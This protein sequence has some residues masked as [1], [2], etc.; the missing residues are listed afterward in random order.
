MTW[1]D[2]RRLRSGLRVPFRTD[3]EVFGGHYFL[4]AKEV[5]IDESGLAIPACKSGPAPPPTATL[6]PDPKPAQAIIERY[7]QAMGGQA[8]IRSHTSVHI[9]GQLRLPRSK[10]FSS[11]I[12][13]F[14]ALT[15]RFFLKVQL[16]TGLHR[17]GCDGRRFWRATGTEVSFA[18]GRDLDQ[19]LALRDFSAVLHEPGAYRSMETLGTVNLD[20]KTCFQ[21]LLV[22]KDGEVF[23]EFYDSETGSCIS[24]AALTK[25]TATASSCWKPTM[26]IA[27]SATRWCPPGRSSRGSNM[28]RN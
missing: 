22:R 27:A 28:L 5:R 25:R 6:K 16:P 14:S 2:Y 15:N 11:P 7:V 24:G 12:E 13:I 10:G 8:A 23:D 19:C 18:A 21:V 4:R 9:S 3:L 17:Q 26:T 20:G 1:S